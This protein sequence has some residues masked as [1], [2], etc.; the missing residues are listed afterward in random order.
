MTGG[1]GGATV[2]VM[3]KPT[4]GLRF[5]FSA[6]NF[7]VPFFAPDNPRPGAGGTWRYLAVVAG[8]GRKFVRL[9]LLSPK[10]ARGRTLR[11]TREQFLEHGG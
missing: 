11:M 6:D 5:R 2:G 1:E 8:V 4:R 7:Q 3:R 9:S 10:F